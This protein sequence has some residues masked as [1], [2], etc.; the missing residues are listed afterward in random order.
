MSIYIKCQ[1][2]LKLKL[3]I[4][5]KKLQ[6]PYYS[7][8]PAPNG[9]YAGFDIVFCEE[10]RSVVLGVGIAFNSISSKP[11]MLGQRMACL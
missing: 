1:P 7:S 8:F 2:N 9:N 3:W 11:S 4:P 5:N 10:Q 6:V